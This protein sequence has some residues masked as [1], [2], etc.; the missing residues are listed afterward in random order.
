MSIRGKA[1]IVGAFEHPLRYAPAHSVAQ[2][3]AEC[4]LGALADAGLTLADV[5]GYFCAGDAGASPAT[6]VDHMN[7]RLRHVDGTEIGGGS[8]LALIGH[9]AQAI[10]SGKCRVALITL[11]G[12]PRSAGQA[13]GT[14]A[15]QPG[16]DRPASAWEAPYRWTVAGIYGNF[17][18]RH[19]HE[20][21][22]TSEQLAWVKVAAS[23]HAQHNEHALLRKVYSV[24]DVLAS[25]M[26]A[27]PLH[28]LDC[29]VITDGGGA[30][31]LAA[32][33]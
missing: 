16:P 22:T 21:G 2:L 8:Y 3:H 33:R 11:A 14:E 25:P 28:R 15:R 4:A 26:I 32:P 13:T 7:L 31:V 19:M 23:H 29:C 1:Y 10:A 9:A 17:A 20:Y 27:D 5:D 18:R 30:L 12:K 6:L 24:E